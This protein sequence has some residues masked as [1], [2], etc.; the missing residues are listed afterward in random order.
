MRTVFFIL[1]AVIILSGC[2]DK[3]TDQTNNS[4]QSVIANT[5][6]QVYGTNEKIVVSLKNEMSSASYFGHCNY[7]IGFYIERKQNSAWNDA[8]NIAILCLAI[9]PS[10]T[11]SLSASQSYSDTIQEIQAGTYRLKFPYSLQS[12]SNLSDSL[13]SNEFVV[14]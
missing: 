14:Q 13:F 4:S 9:Y 6:K 3:T 8:G 2:K 11:L 5:D 7:R 1:F 10:G 12:N